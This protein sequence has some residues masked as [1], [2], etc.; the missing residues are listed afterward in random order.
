MAEICQLSIFEDATILDF[1]NFKNFNG[2][3]SQ[4]DRTA[5]ES[6]FR[7]NRL[8]SGRDMAIFQFFKMAAAAILDF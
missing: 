6:T 4:E 5:S 7:Q 2:R 8:Y 3:N 1:R